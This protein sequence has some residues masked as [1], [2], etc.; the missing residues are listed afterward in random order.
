MSRLK[1]IYPINTKLY[2]I[3]LILQLIFYFIKSEECP[4]CFFDLDLGACKKEGESECTDCYSNFET[5]KCYKKNDETETGFIYYIINNDTVKPMD[6]TGCQNKV[7][8]KT[9]E[10]VGHCPKYTY[11]LGDFCYIEN[12]IYE[13]NEESE[14]NQL[15]DNYVIERLSSLECKYK[16]IIKEISNSNRKEYT[17]LGKEIECVNNNLEY[18]YYDD[19]TNQ[20]MKDCQKKKRKIIMKIKIKDVQMIAKVGNIYFQ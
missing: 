18:K 10:C 9:S 13:K 4:D 8:H 3:F 20:C 2:Y 12:E 16:Y 15:K 6:T 14:I 5:K 17:C 11:E 1:S 19:K 7:I